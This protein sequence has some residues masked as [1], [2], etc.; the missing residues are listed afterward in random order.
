MRTTFSVHTGRSNGR[1]IPLADIPSDPLNHDRGRYSGLLSP[2][3]RNHDLLLPVRRHRRF[4]KSGQEL[5]THIVARLQGGMCGFG[6]DPR[7]PQGIWRYERH[8]RRRCCNQRWRIRRAGRPFGLRKVDPVADGCRPGEHYVR[9]NPHWRPGGQQPPA[10]G[11][12][13]CHGV[14]ELRALPP[15][16]GR[17]QHGLLD[18]AAR[19]A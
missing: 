8:P 9:R 7:R 6:S 18:E 1:T 2:W 16:D 13:R 17:R 11:T 19:R 4:R 15:H 14:P 5:K 12:R 3:R 10:E